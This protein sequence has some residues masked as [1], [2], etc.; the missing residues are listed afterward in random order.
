MPE[1]EKKK[2]RQG[3]GPATGPAPGPTDVELGPEV[4]PG[5]VFPGRGAREGREKERGN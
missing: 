3:P 4:T 2:G 1:K 5:P